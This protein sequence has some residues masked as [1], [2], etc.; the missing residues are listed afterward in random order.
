MVLFTSESCHFDLARDFVHPFMFYWSKR[1]SSPIV[2]MIDLVWKFLPWWGMS[3]LTLELEKVLFHPTHWMKQSGE[4]DRAVNATWLDSTRCSVSN[5]RKEKRNGRPWYFLF[6]TVPISRFSYVKI[7]FIDFLHS[8]SFLNLGMRFH[9][10]GKVV[11]PCVTKTLI[12]IINLW[13]DLIQ[14]LISILKLRV[15]FK[16]QINGKSSQIRL[17]KKLKNFP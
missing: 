7:F 10:R 3:A 9:L 14:S 13:L 1:M 11:T 15:K 4:D 2:L 6:S 12:T 8:L 17:L 16:F 5:T